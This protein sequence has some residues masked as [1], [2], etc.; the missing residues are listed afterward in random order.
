MAVLINYKDGSS[1]H[2]RLQVN[3]VA[4]GR[5]MEKRDGQETF[6]DNAKVTLNA[7]T[8]LWDGKSFGQ[9]NPQ[10]TNEKGEYYFQVPDGKYSLTIEKNGYKKQITVL[11]SY[12]GPIAEVFYTQIYKPTPILGV[13]NENCFSLNDITKNILN[14]V[15]LIKCIFTSIF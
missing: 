3:I 11:K 12:N 5:V 6:V 4:P 2:S 1:A 10:Y 9:E 8:G 13:I 14:I 15:K 7:D